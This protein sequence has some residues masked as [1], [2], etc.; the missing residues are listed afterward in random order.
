MCIAKFLEETGY[1]LNTKHKEAGFLFKKKNNNTK[2]FL[3]A[4]KQWLIIVN[5]HYCLILKL[6]MDTKKILGHIINFE[7]S[8][9]Q[10]SV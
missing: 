9:K 4:H 2:Q 7:S 5:T 1:N 3:I 8:E 10:T 6:S